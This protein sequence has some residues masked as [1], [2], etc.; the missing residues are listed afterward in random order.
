[1]L[2]VIM[3][4]HV[5]DGHIPKIPKIISNIVYYRHKIILMIGKNLQLSHGARI[6]FI[7]FEIIIRLFLLLV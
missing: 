1:M 5:R 7:N 2:R 4:N 3:L 6:K